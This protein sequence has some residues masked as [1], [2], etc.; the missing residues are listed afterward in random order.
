MQRRIIE[1]VQSCQYMAPNAET[2]LKRLKEDNQ[3]C[4]FTC[5]MNSGQSL[6]EQFFLADVV[7]SLRLPLKNDPYEA[8]VTFYVEDEHIQETTELMQLNLQSNQV[9]FFQTPLPLMSLPF[10]RIWFEGTEELEMEFVA[11]PTSYHMEIAQLQTIG[12]MQETWT[13][14]PT[15]CSGRQY[16]IQHGGLYPIEV[17]QSYFEQIIQPHVHAY[18]DPI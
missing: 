4:R 15:N 5:R 17:R 9:Y 10:S 11:I 18:L 3:S 8:N 1:E 13:F 2:L 16:F 14:F 6:R 12:S 7:V